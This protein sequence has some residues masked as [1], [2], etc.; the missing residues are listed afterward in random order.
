MLSKSKRYAVKLTAK[1]IR[2]ELRVLI[3]LAVNF[4][5][6]LLLFG[7]VSLWGWGFAF[8]LKTLFVSKKSD[9]DIVINKILGRVRG[10][11]PVVYM[12]FYGLIQ[13]VFSIIS[14]IFSVV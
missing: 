10:F 13:N 2:R 8:C 5:A 6:Y 4:T 3:R 7:E 11:Y 14:F 1:R 9:F 12:K